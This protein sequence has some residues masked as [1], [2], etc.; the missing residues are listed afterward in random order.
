M[1]YN[2]QFSGTNPYYWWLGQIVDEVNWGGNVNPK[3]HNRD[4]V[5]GWGYRYKV[6][7]FGRDTKTK[8]TPDDQLEMADVLLPVTAGSGHAG[9]T[10][11]VN[12]RQGS[13]V[14]GFYKDGIDAREPII[15]GVLPNNSQTRLFG[16]DPTQGFVPRTGYVGKIGQKPVAT[17]NIYAEGPSSPAQ[18]E[19]N[20]PGQ[21]N[22][23]QQHDQKK[24]GDR[25]HYVPKT[26]ACDGPGGEVKGVRKL[27]R[28]ALA[29]INRIKSE[30]NRFIGAASDLTA[31]ISQIVS[32]VSIAISGL[33]KALLDRMRGYIVNKLNNGVKDLIDM[34]P[35]NKRPNA[36][37]ANET[38]TDVIQ[39]VFNKIVR[40][41]V[42][43]IEKLLKDIIDKYINAPLCA[44]EAFIGNFFAS[45]LGDIT[46]AIN[47]ALSAINGIIGAVSG[48]VNQV[49]DVLNVVSGVLKFLSCE[50]QV[51]CTMGDEWSFWGAGKCAIDNVSAGIRSTTNRIKNFV[52]SGSQS[53]PPCNTAQIPCGPP[54]ISINGGGG[55]G[56]IG[57]PIISATGSILGI[58]LVS[59]GFGYFSP[60]DIQITDGCGIGNG[61]IAVAIINNP[62]TIQ[63]DQTNIN[64]DNG[65]VTIVNGDTTIQGGD[66]TVDGNTINSSGATVTTT[67]SNGNTTVIVTDANVSANGGQVTINSDGSISIEGGIVNANDG[68]IQVNGIG[69]DS[70][71]SISNVVIV[72]PGSGYLP[73]ENGTTGGNGSL[74]SGPRDTIVFNDQVGY[75][76]YPPNTVITVSDTDTIYTPAGSVCDVYD[77]EGNVLQ[78]I[79]GEG[80]T[81]PI[82]VTN[83]GTLTTP[84]IIE[85]VNLVEEI[86]PSSQGSYPVV[87]NIGDVAILNGGI[88]YDSSDKIVVE[89]SNGAELEPV[90]NDLGK[91]ID[92]KIINPGIGFTEFPNIFIESQTGINANI[93]PVFGILRIGDLPEDQ[94]IIP[95]GTEI[96]NVVDCVGK[97]T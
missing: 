78:T 16:G 50:E 68:N 35:P 75:N 61:A 20:A 5:P 46:G 24:D 84:D 77:N 56:A 2:N 38:A 31:G 10:Q 18:E 42:S 54:T 47:S 23:V 32:D 63:E 86:N 44:V 14:V 33:M 7:I 74:F 4:D 43:L 91:L 28:Q 29:L 80:G 81:V 65:N 57:N 22:N 97:V 26:K 1:L 27:I 51:D 76:V 12:L 3:I 41:L 36:N 92:V 73:F 90:F 45:I 82:D 60:P 87:L 40:G 88:N 69:T 64:F 25:C 48:I 72:D 95:P 52:E 59:R 83:S 13:Y 85:E 67:T 89:P 11:S 6:R 96:I 9:S 70:A 39:C 19:A 49:F 58:D 34:L 71:G 93:V 79:R 21:T 37:Q 17:K 53:A 94:D 30:A 66:T 15:T 8:E 62:V 55:F